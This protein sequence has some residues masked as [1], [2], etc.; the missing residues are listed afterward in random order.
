MA[1]KFEEQTRIL[2]LIYCDIRDLWSVIPID[3]KKIVHKMCVVTDTILDIK[4][5]LYKLG[6]ED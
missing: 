3:N 5:I 6:K 2:A 4:E 1:N